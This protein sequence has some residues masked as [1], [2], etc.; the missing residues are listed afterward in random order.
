MKNEFVDKLVKA[1]KQGSKY[2]SL[3]LEHPGATAELAYEIQQLFVAKLKTKKAGYKAAV[4]SEP[5]Q[6]LSLIHI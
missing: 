5:I 6:K 2:P 1:S 4:T 3:S